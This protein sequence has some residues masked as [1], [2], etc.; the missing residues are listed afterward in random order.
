MS[1]K[2]RTL[3]IVLFI[4]LLPSVIQAA[5]WSIAGLPSS[6]EGGTI[7]RTQSHPRA[8]AGVCQPDQPC[9]DAPLHGSSAA[10]RVAELAIDLP[11][12]DGALRLLPSDAT[13]LN[14]QSSLA[15]EPAP[16]RPAFL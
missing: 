9:M 1:F 5:H 6:H 2:A 16:P 3:A 4:G 13:R 15:P 7:E 14:A 12:L 10:V 8:P 11:A